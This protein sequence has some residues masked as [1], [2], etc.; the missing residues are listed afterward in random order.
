MG[1][2]IDVKSKLKVGT[3]FIMT[4]QMKAK[5]KRIVN[6]ENLNEQEIKKLMLD[7]GAYDFTSDFYSRF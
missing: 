7:E 1:G 6:G 2:K 3:R 4:L 5:N